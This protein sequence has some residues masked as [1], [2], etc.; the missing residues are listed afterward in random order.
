[1]NK[2]LL[3]AVLAGAGWFAYPYFAPHLLVLYDRVSQQLRDT[4]PQNLMPVP[5]PQ[6]HVL[7]ENIVNKCTT[8]DGRVIYGE[9]PQGTECARIEEV[10]GAFTVLPSQAI[11]SAPG[12]GINLDKDAP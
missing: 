4:A 10:D 2:L 6:K 5:E 8:V 7:E 9:V 11:R 1:M 12:K 3:V